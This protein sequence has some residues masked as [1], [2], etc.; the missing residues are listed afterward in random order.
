MKMQRRLLAIL[1]ILV[2]A[3]VTACGG[4]GGGGNPTGTA[5]GNTAPPAGGDP[6]YGGTLVINGGSDIDAAIGLPE[7]LMLQGLGLLCP[8]VET[9]AIA[10]KDGSVEPW[11]AE[12]WVV[13]EDAGAINFKLREG[14]KFTDGS[15]FNADV[16]VWNYRR[17]METG[18]MNS[19]MTGVEKVSDYEIRVQ[20][21][22][23]SS[24]M[25]GGFVSRGYGFISQKNY[26]ENGLEYA[27]EHPVGTGPFILDDRVA[28]SHVTFKKNENYWQEGKPYLDA[29]RFVGIQDQ[30]TLQESMKDTG[31]TAV[32]VANTFNAESV[33]M[34]LNSGAP[35]YVQQ[36]PMGPLCLLPG[37]ADAK[38]FELNDSP[39]AKKEVRE[40]ISYALNRDAII[41]ARG[42]GVNTP[43]YQM[44]PE[45]Y[46]GHLDEAAV[47]GTPMDPAAGYDVEKAKQMLADAGYPNGFTTTLYIAWG[48]AD[49]DAMTAVQ[50]QLK[51]VGITVNLESPEGGLFFELR[52]DWGNGNI[53]TMNVRALETEA[54]TI[55]LNFDYEHLYQNSTWRPADEMEPIQEVIG[56]TY[57]P[58][59]PMAVE[60][61]N[62]Q[63]LV[64]LLMVDH[65]IMIPL[66]DM[67]DCYVIRNGVQGGGWADW[68]SG[69]V[70]V[71]GDAW[72]DA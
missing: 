4:G 22:Y 7:R 6:V 52:N 8:W 23:Y 11:L 1:M 39:L 71:P 44:F 3:F 5:G 18:A 58:E 47:K 55:G 43:A 36:M 66:Y 15:D 64:K 49:P 61:D 14:V 63:A 69:T 48:L 51:A 20:L 30:T 59:R 54:S 24:G 70:W 25:W 35:V 10:H 19:L 60:K 42:F 37:S 50:E 9:L 32:D 67:Y 33:F 31:P 13:D 41:A 27:L 40:A 28:G 72:K 53:F 65:Y 17:I 16:A 2:L 45:G 38:T 57:N 34:L 68:G 62:I 26:E 29:L 46:Q 21:R 12:S 56:R